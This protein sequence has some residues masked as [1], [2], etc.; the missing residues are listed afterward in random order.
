MQAR[1]L[2]WIVPFT[3]SRYWFGLHIFCLLDWTHCEL[4][5]FPDL[6]TPILTIK[7]CTWNGAHGEYDWSTLRGCLLLLGTW[8]YLWFHQGSVFALFSG[9]VFHMGFMRLF[10]ARYITLSFWWGKREFGVKDGH[11]HKLNIIQNFEISIKRPTSDNWIEM[12]E[13]AKDPKG[14]KIQVEKKSHSWLSNV[15]SNIQKYIH[16]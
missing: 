8:S 16:M 14:H 12:M 13:I 11:I 1:F 2:L 6:K 10:T 9:F 15:N 5:R 3:W 4:F 7:F